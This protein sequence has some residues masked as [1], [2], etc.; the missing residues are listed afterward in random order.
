MHQK[1]YT[2][3]QQLYLIGLYDALPIRKVLSILKKY[4]TS[5][6]FTRLNNYVTSNPT[7]IQYQI[8]WQTFKSKLDRLELN[9]CSLELIELLSNIT[10]S[11]E[12]VRSFHIE[13]NHL[14]QFHSTEP[15]LENTTQMVY[16]FLA[17]IYQRN[18]LASLIKYILLNP[19][20]KK[21]ETSD[22]IHGHTGVFN[23]I[24]KRLQEL[25]IECVLTSFNGS[26]YDNYLL[27][28]SLILIQTRMKQK[29]H[30]F[31]KGAS[32][33]SILC[34][35]KK[36]FYQRGKK[37]E[38]SLKYKKSFNQWTMKL[39]IKDVRNLV[40]SSMS[41][42][43]IGRL[44]NLP[45][46]KLCFPYSQAKT[47]K[48]IKKL[49]SLKPEDDAFWNDAFSGKKI[50]L[51]NRK[52]AEK[53]FIEKKFTN[54]YDYSTY[55]LVQ[56]C[57]LLHSI[58]LTLFKAHL[59][60]S[61]NIFIRRNYSQ[62]N[63]AY[64]QFFI[65]EP[66]KQI[67]KTLAPKEINNTVYN[68][69]IRQA[70]TG[71]LC[72][73]FVHGKIDNNTIINEHF[74]YLEKPKLST[75]NWP[76]FYRVNE[77]SQHAKELSTGESRVIEWKRPFKETGEGVVTLDIRSLYPSAALK[78]IPV[79]IPLFYTRLTQE[80]D[81]KLYSSGMDYWKTLNLNAYCSHVQNSKNPKNDTFKLISKPAR[82]YNEYYALNYYLESFKNQKN[83]KILRFQSS[84]TA[85]GQFKLN[86]LPVDGFL[87]YLDLNSNIIYIKIIQYQS[88]FFHGHR[89]S[90]HL[91]NDPINA[92]KFNA[93]LAV[94]KKITAFMQHFSNYFKDFLNPVDIQIVEIWDCDFPNHRI[95]QTGGDFSV[96]YKKT[97]N[98]D[99]FLEAI[100]QKKLTGLL[101][102]KNLEIKQINQ[103]PIFGFI[104]QKVKYGLQ[105][106]SP[107]TQEQVNFVNTSKRVISV[108][109]S[110]SFMVIST[111]YFNWLGKTFG[112]EKEPEIY[113]ALFFKLDDYLRTSITTKLEQ[114]SDLKNKIRN[115]TNIKE[116]Q[117][118]EVKAELI[119][120]MLNSCYGFTL[121]NISSEKFKS[122]ENRRLFPKNKKNRNKFKSIYK[123]EDK[124]YLVQKKKK[125]QELFSTL[126]G[127]VGCYILFHSKIILLKRLNFVIQFLNPT[128]AQLLYMD[129]DS[130]HFLVKHKQLKDNVDADIR[131]IFE[132]QFKKHFETGNKISGIW[133]E[134]GFYECAEYIAEK[135]YRLYNIK[136]TNYLTHMKGLNANFQKEYHE[137]NIDRKR[138]AY[139]AFNQFFKSS[140]FI[141][142]KTHM[143]K[144]IFN[145]YVPNKRYFV[146]PTG[147]MPLRM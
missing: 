50:L 6:L 69:M 57:Y 2:G 122:F 36:N 116:K 144:N 82:F 40:S 110:K 62:S 109:K 51:E 141:I 75:S 71:G 22:L 129:T 30:I 45:V 73:S 11:E 64:Q 31:K 27:C 111:E 28:N 35:N 128:L 106:L 49:K 20:I 5:T 48:A 46:S 119:K 17:S 94:K 147:S 41:L 142:F 93:T 87:S 86:K 107:Y 132:A 74:N 123:F 102:V 114:R 12:N 79:N 113:H 118:L 23:L 138:T 34:I 84:F 135:C 100:E 25:I 56:D 9:Q 4:L 32:I 16:T 67:E 105:N 52:E 101:V 59:E 125:I 42:D 78:K 8:N 146:S 47:I 97:Y 33:S 80:D 83:I 43:K 137:K 53:I 126:L 95:P 70:V 18:I 90:C 55:Y 15:T 72:T 60:D 76:N 29:I 143:S 112:F 77:W 133:V 120:L 139:L 61:V 127:H 66:S 145:N 39:Y 103:N 54:L 121:C 38:K 88:V 130:A 63:L 65:I 99:Q 96:P 14:S 140:D 44:F 1:I 124:V 85:L 108:H 68:Y 104:I 89:E 13:K 136:N 37:L 58:V 134:E 91:K 131:F 19:L 115:E 26:N 21:F 81:K 24:H 117:N 7:C 92:T 98:P 3:I 10:L